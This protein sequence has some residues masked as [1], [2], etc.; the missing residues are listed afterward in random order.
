MR[1]EF[2][3]MILIYRDSQIIDIEWIP[4]INFNDTIKICLDLS[5][6]ISSPAEKKIAFVTQRL[7]HRVD[8]QLIEDTIL[9]L[10]EVCQLVFI[11][12]GEL[13]NFHWEIWKRCHR[14]NVHWCVPGYV[15]NREDMSSN[16]IFWGDWFKTTVAL[17]KN[18]PDKLAEIKPYAVKPRYFDAL[19]GSPKPHRDFVFEYATREKLQDKLVMTYGGN[20]QN[21]EFFAKDYF[22][23]EEG[24]VVKK[25]IIGTA[26]WI[27]YYGHQA[28]LSQVIPIQVFNDT[29]YSIIA[30]TDTDNTLSFFSEKTAKPMMAKRLFIAF[31]GYRFLWNLKK[32]GFQ[33]FGNI[34]DESYDV[35]INDYKRYKMAFEQ[36]RLL[37]ERDQ[38][39]VY[40]KIRPVVEHNYKLIMSTNWNYWAADQITERIEALTV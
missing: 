23:W 20:W 13:H 4:R 14:P 33:T 19:L 12:D 34:I 18:L 9:K 21:N 22:I 2:Y 37:C 5:E 28:H 40:R 11:L 16:I 30:E 6:F 17:Y 1:G 27:E 15:N 26:D 25:P 38:A 10:S 39:E 3:N 32:I 31:S 36:V 7:D 29:A 24:T 35:V 8:Q